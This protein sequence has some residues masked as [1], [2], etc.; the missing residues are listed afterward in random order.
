MTAGDHPPNVLLV[1]TD[2]Q[3]QPRHWPEDPG[4]LAS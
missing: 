2:Q 3:R 4:W 1:I